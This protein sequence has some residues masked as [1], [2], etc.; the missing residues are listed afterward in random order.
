MIIIFICGLKKKLMGLDVVVRPP[1]ATDRDKSQGSGP[2]LYE[3]WAG[4]FRGK[5]REGRPPC[6]PDPG[7]RITTTVASFRTWRDL[8]LSIAG[9]PAGLPQS[10]P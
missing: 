9:E 7:T 4:R 6:Q 3:A 8:L 10:P 2:P 1:N 5:T